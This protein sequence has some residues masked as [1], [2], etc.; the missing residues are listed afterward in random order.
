MSI[1]CCRDLD[2]LAGIGGVTGAGF[3]NLPVVE[4]PFGVNVDMAMNVW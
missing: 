1:I 3:V 2:F 4:I